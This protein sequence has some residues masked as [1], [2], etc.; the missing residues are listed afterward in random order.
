[1][2]EFTSGATRDT[3]EGKLDFEGFL[4]APVLLR[5]AEYMHHHRFQADGKVRSSDNWQKGIPREAYMKS[6]W[7]HF[8]DV[9]YEWREGVQ[10][11]DHMEEALCSMLFNVQGLLHE[12]L[13]GRDT[14]AP[15]L[16]LLEPPEGREERQARYFDEMEEINQTLDELNAAVQKEEAERREEREQDLKRAQKQAAREPMDAWLRERKAQREKAPVEMLVEDLYH[17]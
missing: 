17:P 6:L 2:R 12:V 7:R 14:G 13:L 4:S 9:W 3:D 11:E 16:P 15:E 10:G 5:F 1:M 8:F